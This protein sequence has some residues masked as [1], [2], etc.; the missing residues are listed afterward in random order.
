MRKYFLDHIRW[1][2]VLTVLFYHVIWIFNSLGVIG[3]LEKFKDNQPWDVL[4]T[5]IYPW[6]MILLYLIA[7]ISAKYA[8]DFQSN[9]QFINNK[10][11]KLLIPSTLG[12]I[13]YQSF[14]G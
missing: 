12:L 3:G 9:K 8:L 4:L 6:F 10:I 7:G 11:D 2:T 1:I 5:I 13:G 14:I